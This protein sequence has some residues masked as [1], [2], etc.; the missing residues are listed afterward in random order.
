MTTLTP[1]AAGRLYV[2]SGPSGVGK[3]TLCQLLL[4]QRPALKLSISTTSRT[5][6]PGEVDGTHYDFVDRPTFMQQVAQGAFI[7]WAEYNGNCYG[8][9][10]HTVEQALSQGFDLLLEI[11]VQGA[12]QVRERLADRCCLIMVVPPTFETLAQRLRTRATETDEVIQRRLS[13]SQHELTQTDAFDHVVVNDRLEDAL[14]QLLV[15]IPWRPAPD[16]P[17]TD[18]PS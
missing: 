5:M 6:R 3:G 12:L 14:N 18:N 1:D 10:F 17:A 9:P 15:I 11:E 8:T 4:P 16:T 2:L 7:E 13:I